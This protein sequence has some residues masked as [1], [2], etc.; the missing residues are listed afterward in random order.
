MCKI[1]QQLIWTNWKKRGKTRHAAQINVLV[2]IYL[3]LLIALYFTNTNFMNNYIFGAFLWTSWI[4]TF[5]LLKK[6][7]RKVQASSKLISVFFFKT[8]HMKDFDSVHEASESWALLPFAFE[9]SVTQLSSVSFPAGIAVHNS[10]LLT[11]ESATARPDE[12][13]TNVRSTSQN[14]PS[15]LADVHQLDSIELWFVC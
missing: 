3:F 11:K 4:F 7:F 12:H 14:K 15:L 8:W 9:P 13:H 5:W 1:Q 10:E 2:E 6:H